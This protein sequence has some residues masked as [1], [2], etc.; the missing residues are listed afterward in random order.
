MGKDRIQCMRCQRIRHVAANCNLEMPLRKIISFSEIIAGST[1]TTEKTKE[2]DTHSQLTIPNHH[3][4]S[5]KP[6]QINSNKITVITEALDI[7]F[8]V[9]RNPNIPKKEKIRP[10]TLNILEI[11]R[12]CIHQK[13]TKC[14]TDHS[15]NPT[16]ETTILK[17]KLQNDS[18]L[19]LIAAYATSSGKN[20]FT[21]KLKGNFSK[22]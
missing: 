10:Q 18:N 22:T 5:A 15:A 8:W 21:A 14:Q 17:L 1:I 4:K 20:E 9:D 12:L 6:E 7:Q 13:Q 3:P 11:N 16:F 2:T 19:F